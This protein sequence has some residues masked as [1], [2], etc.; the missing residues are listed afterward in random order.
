MISKKTIHGFSFIEL[1]VTLAILGVLASAAMPLAKLTAQRSKESE[2]KQNLRQIRLAIDAYKQAVDEGQ[3][4]R[5]SLSSGYPA[6]LNILVSGVEDA[7][8]PKHSNIYFLRKMPR[9]PFAPIE[10]KPEDTW[11]KRSYASP[12]DQAQEGADVFDVY[13]T[14]TG[15]GLNGIPYQAW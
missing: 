13:S 11:G 3:I 9:D 15:I 12:P 8:D 6:S 2:L 14:N 10:L 4:S 7:R 5:S 1:M